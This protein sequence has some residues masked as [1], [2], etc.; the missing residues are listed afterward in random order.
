[1]CTHKA[2]ASL[3]SQRCG[4]I[5]YTTGVLQWIDTGRT[6]GMERRRCHPVHDRTVGKHGALPREG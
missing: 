5:A 6:G 2:A 4:G 3:G 1:M